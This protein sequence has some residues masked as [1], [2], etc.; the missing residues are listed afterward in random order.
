[1]SHAIYVVIDLDDLYTPGM[2]HW[3]EGKSSHVKYAAHTDN[4]RIRKSSSPKVKLDLF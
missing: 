2:T 4:A 1:M 3:A